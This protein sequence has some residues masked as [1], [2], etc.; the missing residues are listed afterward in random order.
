MAGAR[1]F[2]GTRE[3]LRAGEFH[4]AQR[5][6]ATTLCRLG[7]DF[8]DPNPDRPDFGSFTVE[9]DDP[10]PG[11]T[12]AVGVRHRVSARVGLRLREGPARNS[13]FW[14]CCALGRTSSWCQP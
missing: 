12:P 5:V 13:K 6:P 2:R 7:V 14:G 11:L 1:G 9:D 8:N 4:L 10:R 3:A